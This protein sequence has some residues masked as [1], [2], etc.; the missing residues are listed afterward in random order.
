VTPIVTI[1]R[2]AW[3][4]LLA[5]A[6]GHAREGGGLLIG[7]HTRQGNILVVRAIGVT[8]ERATDS[9]I[10]YDCDEMAKARVAAHTIYAPQEPVGEWHTH[11]HT[12]CNASALIPQCDE[13]DEK[14]ILDGGVEVIVVTYPHPGYK[15][16]P[17]DFL[18]QRYANDTVCR[19]E[20][21]FKDGDEAKPCEIR[22]R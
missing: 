4:E 18:L 20:A 6:L 9:G 19:A 15:Q 7:R 14:A 21:W 2:S 17:N 22:L 8:H 16:E 10:L 5:M 11:P 3:R 1:T 12:C 13:D